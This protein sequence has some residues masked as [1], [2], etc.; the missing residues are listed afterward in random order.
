MPSTEP[1]HPLKDV[2]L[3]PRRVF[4]ELASHPVGLTDYLLAAAQ[5]V[6]TSMAV[7][8]TQFA[9]THASAA[10]VLQSSLLFGP[11]GG[12]VSLYLFAAIYGRLGARAGGT[13]KRNQVF[14][15]LAYGG[16][17]VAASLVLWALTAFIVGE[18]AIIDTPVATPGAD[19]DG[20]VAF[21]LRLQF[22]GYVLLLLWS[23]VLQVMGFSEIQGLT[24]RKAFG[25]WVLGQFLALL[26]AFFLSILIA[27]LFPGIVPNAPH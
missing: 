22:A 6:A 18:A 4:R 20:F 25:V 9:G 16:V 1:V 24:T 26:A 17:P 10:D 27:L 11:I 12:V 19:V 5:G 7:Y 13:S 2:W 21:V 3:K 23:V 8:R 15:V 14:H